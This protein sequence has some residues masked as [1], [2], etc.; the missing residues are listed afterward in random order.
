M[1]DPD[2]DTAAALSWAIKATE[3]YLQAR[4]PGPSA[5]PP[6]RTRQL[7]LLRSL[8]RDLRHGSPGETVVP[9]GHPAG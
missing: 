2:P 5:W 9:I 7:D 8:L 6:K 4:Y 3:E 1:T